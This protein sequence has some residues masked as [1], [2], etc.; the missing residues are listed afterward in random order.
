MKFNPLADPCLSCGLWKGKKNPCIRPKEYR[1]G[2]LVFIGEGPGENE[3]N[4]GSAFVGR[5]GEIIRTILNKLGVGYFTFLNAVACRP[6]DGSGGNRTPSHREV[7]LCSAFLMEDIRLLEPSKLMCLGRIAARAVGFPDTR[8]GEL[9]H[10][11]WVYHP[12]RLPQD[13]RV[14]AWEASKIDEYGSQAIPLWVTYHPAA[15]LR[16]GKANLFKELENDLKEYLQSD[17]ISEPSIPSLERLD[18]GSHTKEHRWLTENRPANPLDKKA[19]VWHTEVRDGE[20]VMDIETSG[21]FKGHDAFPFD[22]KGVILNIGT[23]QG[24][25]EG[26]VGKPW[27]EHDKSD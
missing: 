18:L 19:E 3:D 7:Q 5:A 23:D 14:S 16:P 25:V 8:L 12:Y 4:D 24:Q 10:R 27:E 15:G 9:R 26:D 1:K 21:F 11:K 6:T 17:G 2:G 20:I 13:T 22:G